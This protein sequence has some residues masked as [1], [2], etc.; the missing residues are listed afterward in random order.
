M[1]ALID[2]PEHQ[3]EDL[4]AIGAARKASRT[5]LVREAIDAFIQRYRPARGSA[6]GL[7]RAQPAQDGDTPPQDGLDY[8]ERLRSEW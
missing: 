1:R 4:A 5:Q 8:Q 2:I 3:I 6:F 7:W